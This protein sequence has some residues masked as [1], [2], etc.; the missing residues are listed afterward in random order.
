M[1]PESRLMGGSGAGSFAIAPGCHG[2]IK[3]LE[4]S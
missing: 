4:D 1:L 2:M 3:G